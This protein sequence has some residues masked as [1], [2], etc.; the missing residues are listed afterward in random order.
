MLVV[1]ADDITGAAEIA[2]IGFRFGLNVRLVT[3]PEASP[4]CDLLVYA[5]DTRS[6][7]ENEAA[8][9]T[10]RVIRKLQR[11]GFTHF[12]KKTDSAL[13]GHIIAEIEVIMKE[14]GLHKTLLIPQNPS[15]GRV[16]KDGVYWINSQL[17]SETSFADDP[18]FPVLTSDVKEYLK[19][20][21]VIDKD[22][23]IR[24]GG[25]FIANASG[26]GDIRQH[27]RNVENDKILFAGG[28]DF[29]TEYLHSLGKTAYKEPVGF[30]GLG[31]KDF[32]MV[33]GSTVN[34]SLHELDYFKRRRAEFCSMPL[35]VF[36]GDDPAEWYRQLEQL[37]LRDKSI[38]VSIGHPP[39]GGK[40]NAVRLRNMMGE[41]TCRLVGSLMP[42]ELLIEGGA[43]TF[44]ILGR[45]GWSDFQ[46][47]DEIAPGVVRMP[48]PDNADIHVTFKPGSYGWGEQIFR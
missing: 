42:Q 29:F 8:K 46:L 13:R 24:E 48:L 12:Y 22:K 38:V 14:L 27:I 3:H 43:T 6:M 1:I 40:E 37:Y 41:I 30:E 9:E 10:E 33:C 19:H 11:L 28:A 4:D 23:G 32:I 7:S 16:I 15:R 34:H 21:K 47:T 39:K 45:L 44:A 17:I 26:S 25:V 18:E 36:E 31:D 35:N 2:G 20:V 5:T